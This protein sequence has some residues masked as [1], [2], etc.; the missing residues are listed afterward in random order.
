MSLL[1]FFALGGGGEIV[2]TVTPGRVHIPTQYR[3][4]TDEQ[5]QAR[6]LAQGILQPAKPT[7]LPRQNS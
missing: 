6:R 4:E 1:L 2:P 7:L 3:G 5:K